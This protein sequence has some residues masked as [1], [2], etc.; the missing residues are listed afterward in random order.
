MYFLKAKQEKNNQIETNWAFP[1]SIPKRKFGAKKRKQRGAFAS[2][3]LIL[4]KISLFVIIFTR[5]EFQKSKK[6]LFNPSVTEFN[7]QLK[8]N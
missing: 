5:K 1:S 7:R 8:N 4:Q 6:P 2:T 3:S